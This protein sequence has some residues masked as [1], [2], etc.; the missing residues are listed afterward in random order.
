[1]E[2]IAGN[3][4][5]AREIAFTARSFSGTEA[6]KNGNLVFFINIIVS[7]T[8]GLVSR[9][10]ANKDLCL[11]SA[12]ELASEIASKSPVTIY[13]T[14]LAMNYARDH[15]THDSLEW[16]RI[17]NAAHLQTEDMQKI[18]KSMMEKKKPEFNDV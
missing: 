16:I 10:F 7:Y 6:L 9:T 1:M 2:K 5:W 11:S 14:K 3:A 12:I 18:A 13:G 8:L 15:T 4:S 17:H